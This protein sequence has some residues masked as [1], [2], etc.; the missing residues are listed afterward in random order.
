MKNVST[1]WQ[2]DNP[3]D[4]KKARVIT[5]VTGIAILMLLFLT[6]FRG[7]NPPP[8][9]EGIIVN[10]GNMDVG[11]GDVQPQNKS[12]EIEAPSPPQKAQPQPKPQPQVVKAQEKVLTQ[13]KTETLKVPTSEKKPE[14]VKKPVVKP[15]PK[16]KEPVKVTKPTEQPVTKPAEEAKPTPKP[17]VN[18]RA[19]YPGKTDTNS[20]GE[21]VTGDQ[22]DQGAPNGD[23]NASNHDGDRSYGTGSNGVGYSLSGRKMIASPTVSDNS[24]A[25]GKITVKIKVDQNG[26]VLNASIGKPT[27]ISSAALIN[28]AIAAAYKAKFDANRDAAEEQFGTL[29]F[30]FKVT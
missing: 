19:L 26:K 2:F 17:T 7:P 22:G 16:P 30:V 14:P 15:Q 28:K 20:S 13:D 12:N 23:P 27:T 11:S 10:L 4:R 6:A 29:T 24:N 21:G 25:T 3:A 1:I 18:K 9:E 5:T 8:E